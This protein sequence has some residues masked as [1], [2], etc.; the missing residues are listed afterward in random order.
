MKQRT[1]FSY[2]FLLGVLGAL[3]LLS[4]VIVACGGDDETEE[5]PQPTVVATSAPAATAMPATAAMTP[6]PTATP[7]AAPTTMAPLEPVEPRLK[8][9]MTP[10]AQQTASPVKA[11]RASAAPLKPMLG[12][13]I[14]EDPERLDIHH[15]WLATEWTFDTKAWT[16]KLQEGV[17]F[18]RNRQPSEYMFTANDVVAT[19]ES[20]VADDSQAIGAFFWKR[21]VGPVENFEVVSDY[22]VVM[23]MDAPDVAIP[24]WLLDGVGFHIIS[25]GHWKAVGDEGYQ[26]DPIGTGAFTFKEL[27][28]NSHYLYEAVEDHWRKTP[29]M[30]ELEFLL[31]KEDATRVAMLL[32]GEVHIVDM[33][34]SLVP[35][36]EEAGFDKVLATRPG[37]YLMGVIGGQ[38][39]ATPEG[40]D[41]SDPNNPLTDVRVRRALALAIN[42]EELNET[43]FAGEGHVQIAHLMYNTEPS[44]PPGLQPY[45][46]DPEEAKQLLTEAGY[47]D[48]FDLELPYY[49]LAGLP[50][51]GEIV[52]AIASYYRA[53]GINTETKIYEGSVL[54]EM[55]RERQITQA[56]RFLNN[57][58]VSYQI[59]YPIN[60]RL[61]ERSNHWFDHPY[62]AEFI[63]TFDTTLDE[64]TRV[65]IAREFAQWMQDN[66]ITVPVLFIFPVLGVDPGVVE[67]YRG[68]MINLGPTMDHEYTKMVKR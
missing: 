13:L 68:N 65:R 52:E 54:R 37:W 25:G 64:D 62:V 17:P 23:N 67:E 43:F 33:P 1:R 61:L 53:I 32:A 39:Y 8:V 15:D 7:T 48:G 57:G 26:L 4:L 14:R 34:W 18:Y 24:I 19:Y 9:A 55:G 21:W 30:D 5:A 46:Y 36:I 47:P 59:A 12:F 49:V 31:V 51:I 44:V 40:E 10:P 66:V 29:E 22:E 45:P 38:F 11:S 6:A 50:N 41:L 42:K 27:E 20:G 3:L 60:L 16:F 56:V 63:D 28:V 2:N 35:Q 58:L